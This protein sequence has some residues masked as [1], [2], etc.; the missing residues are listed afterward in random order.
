MFL[1]GSL[2]ISKRYKIGIFFSK[3]R[4]PYAF[5][6]YQTRKKHQSKQKILHNKHHFLNFFYQLCIGKNKT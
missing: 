4:V 2:F 5:F 1:L 6:L 3:N